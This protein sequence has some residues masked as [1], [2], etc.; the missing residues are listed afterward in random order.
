MPGRVAAAAAGTN[1]PAAT[2]AKIK[3][4]SHTEF[5]TDPGFSFARSPVQTFTRSELLEDSN[6]HATVLRAAFLGLVVS[7]RLVFTVADH[8]HAV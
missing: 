3:T 6:H 7:R 8:V 1:Q 4:A 2:A 5:L